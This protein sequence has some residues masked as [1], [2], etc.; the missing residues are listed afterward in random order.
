[1]SNGTKVGESPCMVAGCPV[2]CT[3][4]PASVAAP[5]CG[6]VLGA[7]S[8][9]V[10]DGRAGG[11]VVATSFAPSPHD[12]MAI[13][14]THAAREVQPQFMRPSFDC[15]YRDSLRTR[16]SVRRGGCL[17]RRARM[18]ACRLDDDAPVRTS[19][20]AKIDASRARSRAASAH[21]HGAGLT[22]ACRATPMNVP[23]HGGNARSAPSGR[24][25]VSD[26]RCAERGAAQLS[27]ENGCK[28]HQARPQRPLLNAR[29]PSRHELLEISRRMC[30]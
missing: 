19:P 14:T 7:G 25:R 20:L 21:D 22:L 29:G 5:S 10:S 16:H 27:D 28:G 1:M 3:P 2:G 30:D 24:G 13:D 11:R 18:A 8:A 17:T 12:T 9:P 6:A 15:P 4:A 23:P 26:V